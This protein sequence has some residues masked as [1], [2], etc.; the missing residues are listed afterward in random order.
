MDTLF[1]MPSFGQQ[2]VDQMREFR[3]QNPDM[4]PDDFWVKAAEL[5]DKELASVPEARRPRLSRTHRETLFEAF[6]GACGLIE[7]E[8]TREAK[9]IAAVKLA[10]ILQVSPA[11]TPEEFQRRAA[12]YRRKYPGAALTPS[13][14]SSHWGAFG[15]G[16][17]TLSQ[18]LDVYREPPNWRDLIRQRG[19]PNCSAE[20]VENICGREWSDIRVSFGKEIIARIQ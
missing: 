11:V 12:A 18:K 19:L 14:L 9:R 6:V 2:C 5:I 10:E 3:R 7:A 4:T 15:S 1:P 16:E 20:T 8:M 17:Q 13:A